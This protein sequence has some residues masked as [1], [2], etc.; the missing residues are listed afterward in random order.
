VNEDR[1]ARYHKLGRRAAIGSTAWSAGFLV[2]LAVTPLSIRLRETI[3]HLASPLVPSWLLPSSIVL[4]YVAA[5]GVV[6]ELGEWPIA[7]YRTFL[8]EH[9]YG[10]SKESLRR[11]G[12]DQVKAAALG[13]CLSLAGFWALYLAMRHWPEWWWLAAALGSAAVAVALTRL[14]PVLLLPLFFTFRPLSRAELRQRLLMLSTRAGVPVTDAS[15][16][17]LSDRTKKANAALAGFGR[18]RRIIVSDTL[19]N[20]Y[21]DDEIEVIL[22]HELAH[23]VHHDIWRGIALQALVMTLGFFAASRGLAALAPRL[24]WQGVADVAGLPVLLLAAGLLSLVLLPAV[25]A[26]SRAME[27][28]ADRFALELTGNVEAFSSAMRRLAE[29]NLSEE[30]PSRFARWLF[31]THPPVGERID[32]AQAWAKDSR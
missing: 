10:L 3:E 16:W 5:C 1:S 24:G 2:L 21:S 22:A 29:Q 27:R 20:N 25:N 32:A 18:T 15:E 30:H 8:L 28:N 12:A 31:Y 14:A 4:A 17:Q 7:F 26:A 19:L 13:G 6:H 9:R 23:Q 11:W